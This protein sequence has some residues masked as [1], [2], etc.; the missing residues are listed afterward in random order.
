MDFFLVKN[1]QLEVL[2]HNTTYK[3]GGHDFLFCFFPYSVKDLIF[4]LHV[5]LVF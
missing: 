2:K 4:N 5:S 3:S 1:R